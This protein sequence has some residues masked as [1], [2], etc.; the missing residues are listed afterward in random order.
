MTAADLRA[1]QKQ[2]QLTNARA[3]A[4]LGVSVATYKRYLVLGAPLAAGLACAALAAR[5]QPWQS[6][7]ASP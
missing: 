1:W 2:M 5:L 7:D 6:P 3:A 4:A